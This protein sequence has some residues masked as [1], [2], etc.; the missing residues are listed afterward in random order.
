MNRGIRKGEALREDIVVQRRG[1]KQSK[2][3]G[4]PKPMLEKGL[5]KARVLDECLPLGVC[6]IGAVRDEGQQGAADSRVWVGGGVLYEGLHDLVR[7]DA[8]AG[9]PDTEGPITF[10]FV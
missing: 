2:K 10:V 6:Q 1:L 3:P 8:K 9:Q 7:Q 4:A 5:V